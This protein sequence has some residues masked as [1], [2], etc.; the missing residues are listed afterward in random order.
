MQ[1]YLI[2]TKGEDNKLSGASLCDEM[3][4]VRLA[5]NRARSN[6]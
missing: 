4:V 1:L 5:D 2:K 6:G 3:I